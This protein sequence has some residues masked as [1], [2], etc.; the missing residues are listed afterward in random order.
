MV[1]MQNFIYQG[2]GAL[3]GSLPVIKIL[4]KSQEFTQCLIGKPVQH[5]SDFIFDFL[6]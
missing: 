2:A 1:F 3:I 6:L 5:L 4:K